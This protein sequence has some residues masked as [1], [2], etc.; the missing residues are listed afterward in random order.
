MYKYVFTLAMK[1]STGLKYASSRYFPV[2]VCALI[3]MITVD[4]LGQS[5]TCMVNK[6]TAIYGQMWKSSRFLDGDL[7]IHRIR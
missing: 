5:Y 1:L 6:T 4:I 3:R 2:K 7:S